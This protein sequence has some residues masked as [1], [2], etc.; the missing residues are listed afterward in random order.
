MSTLAEPGRRVWTQALCSPRKEL[1]G[2]KKR[3]VEPPQLHPVPSQN[4]RQEG[5]PDLGEN[6]VCRN[7]GAAPELSCELASTAWS[8]ALSSGLSDDSDSTLTLQETEPVTAQGHGDSWSAGRGAG[9]ETSALLRGRG[10][11]DVGEGQ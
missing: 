11:P 2:G 4:R 7:L 9:K 10:A 6:Q 1:A 8:P 3:E 5:K